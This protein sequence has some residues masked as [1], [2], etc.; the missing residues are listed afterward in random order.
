MSTTS[1]FVQTQS[2]MH[3]STMRRSPHRDFS[4]IFPSVCPEPGLITFM[5]FTILSIIWLF[6]QLCLSTM[7]SPASP[8]IP[9]NEALS[10][11]IIM[12]SLYAIVCGILLLD[13][14]WLAAIYAWGMT[15]LSKGITDGVLWFFFT[16]IVLALHVIF[17]S[18]GFGFW[19]WGLFVTFWRLRALWVHRSI[20]VG[21]T[22]VT[23]SQEM[24]G[25]DS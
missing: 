8:Q 11:R 17:L 25:E 12:S 21:Q 10:K 7:S 22:D 9:N 3:K 23:K 16:V 15:A 14:C 6:C 1:L 4:F 20:P 24:G 2:H 18:A 13:G 5:A 19:V